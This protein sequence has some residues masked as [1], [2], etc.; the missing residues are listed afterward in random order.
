MTQAFPSRSRADQTRLASAGSARDDGDGDTLHEECGVF[1]VFG[2]ED[3]AALTALGLFALQHRGQE[4]CGIAV[5][6]GEKFVTRRRG[7]L[8]SDNFS[9]PDLTKHMPGASAVGHVRYSTQGASVERNLQ[10][11]FADLASGGFALA[12]NGNLTN[13]GHLRRRL[14]EDGAIFQTESDTEVVLH[15][16]AHSRAAKPEDRFCEA[17]S[18][19]EGGFAL[20]GLFNGALI[21]ARD[22]IGIRP[23]VVGKLGGGWVI[24]SET[25]ALEMV[26]AEFV[27]DVG[28]GE[29]IMIDDAQGLRTVRKARPGRPATCAFEYIY[30]A[31]PD[32][33]VDGRS[34]Y[35]ARKRMGS[36]LAA[37]HPVEAD[38]VVPVPD[39]GMPAAIGYAQASGLPFELGI[40]RSHFVG[41]TFI[42]PGQ[43]ARDMKVRLKHR[44]NA[45]ILNGK[46][47][48]LVDDSIVRGT[49]SRKIVS[50][51]RDAGATE[52]HF[53]SASPPIRY[54][55]YYGI[56]MPER[57]E[58]LAARAP[59]DEAIAAELGADSVAFLSL[60]RLY[61]AILEEPRNTSAPQLTEHYFTGVY[62]TDPHFDDPPT[63]G[64]QMSLLD[65]A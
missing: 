57:S 49:T 12:H 42:Q 26:D 28:P 16:L 50:M 24:A 18:H 38:I 64:R 52:V 1:A 58:L 39:S 6:T 65:V 5:F 14:V 55:D 9:D 35:E 11:L 32:S 13:A 40:I 17:L 59:N 7:G 4:G 47:V 2:V 44:A 48:V 51:V 29:V 54:P 27:R 46:R 53:L 23:L 20:A 22:P 36:G 60:D 61:E 31:R 45:S 21:A 37:L 3:A 25:S 56:D 62:P 15:L 33:V 43:G 34:V 41:R 10:P 8:V 63:K 30:F 19:I